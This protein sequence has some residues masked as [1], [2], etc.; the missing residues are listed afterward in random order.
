MS[1]ELQ[2][3]LLGVLE[4]FSPNVTMKRLAADVGMS[5]HV[6]R[7]NIEAARRRRLERSVL[8]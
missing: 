5:V 1:Q 3:D 4:A 8:A 7:A 2:D 6:L